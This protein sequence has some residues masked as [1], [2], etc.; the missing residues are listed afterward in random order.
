MLLLM[1][2]A[3]D[4]GLEPNESK[5]LINIGFSRTNLSNIKTGHQSF[6]IDQIIK[7]C[8]L[9]G[10]NANWILG[11]E[12]NMKRKESKNPISKMKEL[13]IELESIIKKSS[14]NHQTEN[15]HKYNR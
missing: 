4:T 8:E 2:Y 10:A 9:T 11:I 6:T 3:I 13:T 7:A 14:K 5:F 15:R 12:H 1:K